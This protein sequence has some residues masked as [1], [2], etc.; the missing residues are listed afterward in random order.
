[1]RQSGTNSRAIMSAPSIPSKLTY[2]GTQPQKSPVY[3]Y[4]FSI[5]LSCSFHP[6]T[7][8]V[9]RF[10]PI[11]QPR[12]DILCA[13]TILLQIFN[14]PYPAFVLPPFHS[15][16]SFSP[17]TCVLLKMRHFREQYFIL[18]GPSK[19]VPQYLHTGIKSH[20]FYN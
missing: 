8:F 19:F 7:H 9:F 6:N 2:T 13:N 11:D 16:H 3:S 14:T 4:A 5:L 12:Y 20:M 1:M 18:Y 15:Q 10:P 17:L